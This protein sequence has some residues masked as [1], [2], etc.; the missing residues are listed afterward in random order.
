[1]TAVEVSDL[2]KEFV[3][4]DGPWR[5][6]R[7]PA[8]RGVSFTIERGECVAVLGANGSGKSTLVRL[9]A[10]LLLHDGGS[11][12][13]FGHDVFA[14]PRAVRRL[15]NRVSVEASFFKKMSSTENL[16][17]SARFY[18]MTR[19]ETS[20]RIPEILERV[21]FPVERRGEAMEALSRGMQQKVAL[22]RAL[23]T[24][25]V[26]PAPRRADDGSRSALEA[27]GPG[28]HP[29]GSP[30]PRRHNPALHPRPRTRPRRLA[31]RIGIL[32]RGE[33][34]ALG[35]ADELKRR[36]EAETLE[37]AFFAATG[38][39]L[40]DDDRGGGLM[41]GAAATLRGELIGLAGVVE[42]NVYLVRRYIWWDIAFFVWTVAN[43]LTIV[44]IAKGI[45]AA[46]GKIDVDRTTTILLIGAVIWAYLGI[47]FEILTETVAWERW[48]GTIEYTFMAS[49]RATGAP[50]GHG[51]VLGRLWGHSRRL[52]FRHRGG[53][54]RPAD[55]RTQTS[56][57]R[58]CV[59]AIASI[60]FVGIGMMT[61]V[62]P[63]ISPEKGAS[64][65]VYRPGSPARRLRRLLP[66]RR[67]AGLDA[68]ARS[69]LARRPTRST[70]FGHAILDGAGR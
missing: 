10:T 43:T 70:A 66:G 41:R 20:T 67:A 30:D 31:D 7:V 36:Y 34:I 24:A 4:R 25:P 61:A 2:R 8:L 47:I 60:S 69:D 45:E 37:E 5:R 12:H 27:R 29:R 62:L 53:V 19:G 59:L 54:V 42:R 35:T 58:S 40:L 17:Y 46:G 63:L 22:A 21:G 57:R 32:D 38:R 44:Y 50:G 3:R 68:G 6:R 11:A 23:L 15:V 65:G 9:L 52:P 33:L 56:C 51:P 14:D 48:E 16:S 18:G 55:C 28:V 26:A 49:A 64:A 1:M 39:G 13:V